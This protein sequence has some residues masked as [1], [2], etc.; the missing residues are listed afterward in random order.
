MA[1]SEAL[2]RT[3]PSSAQNASQCL[4]PDTACRGRLSSTRCR[5]SDVGAGEAAMGCFPAVRTKATAIV[6]F[7]ATEDELLFV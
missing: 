1:G 6:R 5:H 4:S 3:S 7:I 2:S